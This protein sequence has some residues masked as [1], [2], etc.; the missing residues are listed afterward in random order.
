MDRLHGAFASLFTVN[1]GVREGERIVVFSDV[2]RG[3][4]TVEPADRDRRQRLLDTAGAA[5]GYAG[6]HFGNASFVAFPATAASGVEPPVQL[7]QAVFGEEIVRQLD[8]DAL[9]E[10]ILTKRTTGA[11]L[12]RAKAI[13]NRHQG[14]VARVVVAMANNS[15]SHT[16]FRWLAN[17]AGTRFASLPHFDPAMFFTSMAVDWQALATLTARL[18]AAVNRG[19][20]MR[21]ST[22][23]GTM[24]TFSIEGRRAE[25]DDGLLTV[26]RQLRQSSGRRGL[27]GSS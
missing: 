3:D 22:P 19:V 14:D 6:L 26:G 23:A 20:S 9:L 5:A 15:T 21:L 25:G 4:E 8:G 18:A 12:E 10:R 27:S 16:R 1:M 7:W 11:D 2:I 17:V 13:V 24:L